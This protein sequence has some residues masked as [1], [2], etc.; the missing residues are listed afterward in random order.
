[1]DPGYQG[2]LLELVLLTAVEHGWA[3]DALPGARMAA[4]LAPHGYDP[5]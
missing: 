5:W 1:V 4:A 2:M 3:L